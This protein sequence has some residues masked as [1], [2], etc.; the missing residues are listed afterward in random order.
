MNRQPRPAGRDGAQVSGPGGKLEIHTT[1]PRDTTP[2]PGVALSATR[3][4]IRPSHFLVVTR[5][6]DWASCD[7]DAEPEVTFDAE[8]FRDEQTARDHA[9]P[10]WAGDVAILAEGHARYDLR[11][12]DGAR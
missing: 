6:V 4:A 12:A 8:A 2:L 11:P 1:G 7:D 9:A 5:W 3:C 10:D